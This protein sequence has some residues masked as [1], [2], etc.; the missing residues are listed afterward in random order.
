L[1][2]GEQQNIVLAKELTKSYEQ[3][4]TNHIKNIIEWLEQD[5]KR[6][7]GEF[8]IIIPA[9]EE[10]IN[11]DEDATPLLKILI[12]HVGAKQAAQIGQE[13]LN[14]PKNHLYTLA[15]KLQKKE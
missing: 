13:F 7:K 14:L 1:I 15:L 11:S 2:L 3:I 5:P 12:Q 8:V 10:K 9:R 6:I 4:Q